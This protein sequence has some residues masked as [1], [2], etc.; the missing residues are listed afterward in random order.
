MA[1]ML[2]D[3]LFNMISICFERAFIVYIE[4]MHWCSVCYTAVSLCGVGCAVS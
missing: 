1:F 3:H 2:Q 4:G